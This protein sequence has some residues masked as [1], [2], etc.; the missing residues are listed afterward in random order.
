[1]LL[2]MCRCAVSLLCAGG[3]YYIPLPSSAHQCALWNVAS[4]GPARRQPP[5]SRHS[6]AWESPFGTPQVCLFSH[7]VTVVAEPGLAATETVRDKRQ[8]R[9]APK[10]FPGPHISLQAAT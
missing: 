7:T 4:A 2:M 3:A 8:S 1:M 9:D 5:Q 10:M 6:Q